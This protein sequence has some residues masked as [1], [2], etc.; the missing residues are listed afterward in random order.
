LFQALHFSPALYD[1]VVK[2]L[3]KRLILVLN[4]VDLAPVEL[5]AAWKNYFED[6]FPLLSVVCFTSHTSNLQQSGADPGSGQKRL[7]FAAKTLFMMCLNEYR[8]SLFA[9]KLLKLV[10]GF[11]S[12]IKCHLLWHL[13]F[14]CIRL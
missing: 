5:V 4:K 1:H 2:D 7:D 11:L 9:K 13:C 12:L 14:M 3:K 6:K 10:V 8:L